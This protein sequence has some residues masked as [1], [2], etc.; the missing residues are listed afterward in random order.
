MTDPIDLNER[1]ALRLISKEPEDVEPANIYEFIGRIHS[2]EVKGTREFCVKCQKSNWEIVHFGKGMP[3]LSPRYTYEAHHIVACGAGGLDQ[4][5]S[6]SCVWNQ[7]RLL[8]RQ[9]SVL[10]RSPG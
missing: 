6:Q 10:S 9:R 3:G 4:P 5:E 8:A 2:G 1:R 7:G